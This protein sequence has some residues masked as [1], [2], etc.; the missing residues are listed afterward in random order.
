MGVI[1]SVIAWVKTLGRMPREA[2]DQRS[3]AS[4]QR[5]EAESALDRWQDDGGFVPPEL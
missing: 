1:L 4:R 2:N 5:I 3:D